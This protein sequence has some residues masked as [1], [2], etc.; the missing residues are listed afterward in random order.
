MQ[1]SYNTGDYINAV[2]NRQRAE[3]ISSVLFPDDRSYQVLFFLFSWL[4][5]ACVYWISLSYYVVSLS[6]VCSACILKAIWFLWRPISHWW[7]GDSTNIF[8]Q[9]LALNHWWFTCCFFNCSVFSYAQAHILFE[10]LFPFL[11][12]SFEASYYLWWKMFLSVLQWVF[13]G[14]ATLLQGKELRLKQQYFFVSASLQDIIRRFKDSHSNFDDF[15]EKV[16]LISFWYMQKI[17]FL[18]TKF[19]S[20]LRPFLGT[21]LCWTTKK[22]IFFW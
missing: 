16:L 15:H 10:L 22:Q 19:F 6:S 14:W 8:N 5:I 17:S 18:T 3:T 20:L 13:I 21:V 12:S 4:I 7:K 2:V 1:E 11:F 9:I